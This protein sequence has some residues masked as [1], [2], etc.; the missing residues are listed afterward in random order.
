MPDAL[1]SR[2][3]E[4]F[5]AGFHDI[6]ADHRSAYAGRLKHITRRGFPEGVAS[7]RGTPAEYGAD[8]LFQLMTAME[9]T[10]FGVMPLRAIALVSEAWPRLRGAV[11][12]L[13][14][15]VEAASQGIAIERPAIFWRVPVEALRHM[16]RPDRGYSPDAEDRLDTM[17]AEEARAALEERGYGLRRYAFI[18]ADQMIHDALTQL[19][20]Q[21][22]G[23][24]PLAAFMQRMISP[25]TIPV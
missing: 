13:W 20:H 16:A 9:L 2:D 25:P 19:G 23:H 7:G 8:Q 4:R 24:D 17:T 5:L 22:G 10:Q 15:V 11:L 21:L 12:D 18:V 1:G 3:V 6:A 14:H